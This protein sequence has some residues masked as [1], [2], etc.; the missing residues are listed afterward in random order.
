[1]ERER[2]AQRTLDERRASVRTCRA[3]PTKAVRQRVRLISTRALGR[4]SDLRLAQRSIFDRC[5]PTDHRFP[6]QNR[7]QCSMVTF[8]PLTAAGQS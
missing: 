8:V 1:M 3:F 6:G 5:A 7:T 2:E 4:F